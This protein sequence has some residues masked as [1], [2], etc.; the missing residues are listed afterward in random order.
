MPDPSGNLM[1]Q[2]EPRTALFDQRSAR[3]SGLAAVAVI[4]GA[5]AYSR[6]PG[7]M[8]YAVLFAIPHAVFLGAR[9]SRK[10]Q[11]WGWAIGWVVSAVALLLAAFTALKIMRLPRLPDRNAGFPLA[12]LLS[13]TAQLIFVRRAFP[14]TIAFGTPLFRVALYYVCVSLSWLPLCRIGM[15]HPLCAM[16]INRSTACANI[17]ALP[18]CMRRVVRGVVQ[19][20]P[21]L[22]IL[23]ASCLSSDDAG[24]VPGSWNQ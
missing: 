10:W 12:L 16:K 24:A 21:Q 1:A 7:F 9:S 15:S 3:V 14:G 23:R 13:Q 22:L 8:A 11:A 2:S 20:P 19:Y 6:E 5:V 17:P 18:N 4:C